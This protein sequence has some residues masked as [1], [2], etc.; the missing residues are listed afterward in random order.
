[1]STAGI[2]TATGTIT[3]T[4]A[5]KRERAGLVLKGSRIKDRGPARFFHPANC[6]SLIA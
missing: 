3:T 4:I 6:Q 2:M 5:A 1:M